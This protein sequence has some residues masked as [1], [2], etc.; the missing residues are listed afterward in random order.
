VD[1]SLGRKPAAGDASW[2]P[3]L[4]VGLGYFMVILDATAVTLV[5]PSVSKDLGGG[6]TGLQWVLDGYTLAFATL[7]LSAGVAG[8]TDEEPTGQWRRGSVRMRGA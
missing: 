4:A 3:L 7:L 8:R 1:T 5:L 2:A 6:V